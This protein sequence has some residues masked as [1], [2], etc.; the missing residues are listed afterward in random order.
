MDPV[1]N[2][3]RPGAG[4]P[5]PAL[6]GRDQLIDAFGITVRRAVSGRPGKSL[7][8]IGLRGV[9]KTVLLNRFGDLA[10]DAGMTAAFIEAPETG[11]FRTLLAVRIR[12]VLL[13]LGNYSSGPPGSARPEDL[14]PP[15]PGRVAHRH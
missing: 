13:E 15:A 8:P 10:R 12:K 14:H 9:G 4:T 1:D 3:Y 7:M 5:P 2:P 6:L 11:D